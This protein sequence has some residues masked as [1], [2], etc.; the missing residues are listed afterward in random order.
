[1]ALKSYICSCLTIYK[2]MK[3]KQEWKKIYATGNSFDSELIRSKLIDSGIECK[4][5]NKKDSAYLFGE[6]ELYVKAED[7][8]KAKY[9]ITKLGDSE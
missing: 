1:M 2:I 4:S 8:I 7:V 3:N 6:I 5:L 9:I